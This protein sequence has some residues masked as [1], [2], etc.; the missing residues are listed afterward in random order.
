MKKIM[1]VLFAFLLA[2]GLAAGA[3]GQVSAADLCVNTD[4]S[5][6]VLHPFRLRLRQPPR[7]IRSP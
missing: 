6:D 7:V 5:V 3:V 4:G 2:F 1:Y